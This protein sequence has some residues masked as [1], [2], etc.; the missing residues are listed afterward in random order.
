MTCSLGGHLRPHTYSHY[1]SW[2]TQLGPQHALWV[3][4]HEMA[5]LKAFDE[6]LNEEGIN[7]ESVSFKLGKTFDAAM[8]EEAWSFLKRSYD[9]MQRDLGEDGEIIRD[10]KLIENQKEAEEF[11]QMKGC[12]AA[13]YHPT[14]QM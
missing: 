1:L 2:A 10:C 12:Y 5:H 9:A 7:P 6:L 4:K 14:G 8:T 13:G 3:I 11:T